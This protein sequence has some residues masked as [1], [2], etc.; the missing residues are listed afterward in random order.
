MANFHDV[1]QSAAEKAVGGVLTIKNEQFD[2]IVDY[3]V[4]IQSA[5]L[6]HIGRVVFDSCVFANIF[7]CKE[8]NVEGSAFFTRCTFEKTANF[9]KTNFADVSFSRSLFC[10]TASFLGT[11]FRKADFLH[12]EFGGTVLFNGAEFPSEMKFEDT[13]FCGTTALVKIHGNHLCFQNCKVYGSLE[14]T[15]GPTQGISFTALSLPDTKI[16]G[17]IDLDWDSHHLESMIYKEQNEYT[18]IMRQFAVLKEL[19]HMQGD[20]DAEDKAF[21]AYMD[22]KAKAGRLRLG[23]K[24]LKMVGGYGTKPLRILVCMLLCVV[25]FFGLQCVCALA[26]GNFQFW[27]VASVSFLGVLGLANVEGVHWSI[28]LVSFFESA[29][30]LFLFSYFSVALVRRTLR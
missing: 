23:Y 24:L 11:A 4:V 15:E 13:K 22:A 7:L 1:V 18:S 21:I 17:T 27:N 19:F 26:L 14:F 8:L 6:M 16:L 12:T 3:A 10:G 9:T 30:G 20:Y 5:S 2:E 28:I 29:I 25:V